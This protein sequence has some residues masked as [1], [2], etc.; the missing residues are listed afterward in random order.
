M[1]FYY[2]FLSKCFDMDK[3]HF[4]YGDTDSM[5]FAVADNKNYDYN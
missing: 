5:M 1:N 2:N 4:A 3:L